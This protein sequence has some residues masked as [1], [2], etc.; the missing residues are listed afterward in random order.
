ML[1]SSILFKVEKNMVKLYLRKKKPDSW[2]QYAKD[3]AKKE[4]LP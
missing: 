2:A 3:L 1:K 4:P